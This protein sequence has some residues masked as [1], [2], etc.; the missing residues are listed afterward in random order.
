[1]SENTSRAVTTNGVA[2]LLA[3]ILNQEGWVKGVDELVAAGDLLQELPDER[4]AG[5]T[6]L[7]EEH[8]YLLKMTPKQ[9]KAAKHCFTALAEKGSL[10]ANTNVLRLAEVLGF[11]IPNTKETI[12]ITLP[13]ISAKYLADCFTM[14]KTKTP[15]DVIAISQVESKLPKLDVALTEKGRE[16]ALKTWM[17][18]P[19]TFSITERQRDACRVVL[20]AAAEDGSVR[21]NRFIPVLYTEFGLRE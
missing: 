16:D 18:Q 14:G 13:Q 2:N 11:E 4:P 1:M 21:S 3:L 20:K 9:L 15:A 8:E 6:N 17:N 10:L 19:V 12:E 5:A 7:W